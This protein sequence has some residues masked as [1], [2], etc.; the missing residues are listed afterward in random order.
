M[1]ASLADRLRVGL[2]LASAVGLNTQAPQ[3]GLALRRAVNG[4]IRDDHQMMS[5]EDFTT[6]TI[7]NEILW[8]SLPAE[9]NL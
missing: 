2:R 5:G 8:C 4:E 1:L 6:I 7:A 3:M 9:R